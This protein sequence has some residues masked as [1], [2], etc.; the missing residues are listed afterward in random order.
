MV[1]VVSAGVVRV[2]LTQFPAYERQGVGVRLRSD[3]LP[4]R[5]ALHSPAEEGLSHPKCHL[6]P[7]G[8]MGQSLVSR[9]GVLRGGLCTFIGHSKEQ[10]PRESVTPR[11]R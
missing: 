2:W 10:S 4:Y 11:K 9:P 7:R 8:D 3:S 6:C 5:T 1:E